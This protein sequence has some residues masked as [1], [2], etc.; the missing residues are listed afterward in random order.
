MWI[1]KSICFMAGWL[2]VCFPDKKIWLRQK[3]Q[4]FGVVGI[5]IVIPNPNN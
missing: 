4:A 3:L 1:R 5:F 2:K